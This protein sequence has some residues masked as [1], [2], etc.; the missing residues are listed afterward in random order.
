MA[1]D[2]SFITLV[3]G[4]FV[5]ATLAFFFNRYLES[6]KRYLE[7]LV[8]ANLAL[9]TIKNQYN[10]FL[11]FRKAFRE[12]VARCSVTGN[13]P[14][15]SLIRPTLLKLEG[16]VLDYKSIGFLL[17]SGKDKHVF[18]KLEQVQIFHRDLIH[19]M[20][21]TNEHARLKQQKLATLHSQKPNSTWMEMERELGM[22]IVA[23]LSVTTLGLATR[24]EKNESVYLEAF[25]A[26]RQALLDHLCSYGEWTICN[27]GLPWLR[28]KD[29]SELLFDI[30]APRT[31]FNYVELCSLPARLDDELK[32]QNYEETQ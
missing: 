3:A 29:C 22:D 24:T 17:T 30:N 31:G 25:K 18:D 26:L 5:G 13:E 21:V 2:V 7:Q 10:D 12:D 1:S 6:R 14:I 9:L 8:S 28:R 19:M 15:W 32:L 4:P 27:C 11:L 16:Y 23:I 20:E